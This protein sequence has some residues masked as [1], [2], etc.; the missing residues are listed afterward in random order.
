MDLRDLLRRIAFAVCL[1]I[2]SGIA[3]AQQIPPSVHAG[4]VEQELDKEQ[5]YGPGETHLFTQIPPPEKEFS[6][7]EGAKTLVKE[8]QISGN[9]AIE[10]EELNNLIISPYIGKD[11][12]N[13]DLN[14]IKNRVKQEYLKCGLTMPYV[15]FSQAPSK[16]DALRLIIIEGSATK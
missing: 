8:I 16:Q 7:P 15:Y 1:L 13:S 12:T 4:S 10:T 14:A 6:L 9:A 3:Y 11:L 2:F 5:V